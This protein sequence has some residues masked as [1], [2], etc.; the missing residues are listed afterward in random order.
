MF[1]LDDRACDFHF[2]AFE[3]DQY[4]LVKRECKIIK[5]AKRKKFLVLILRPHKI[6]IYNTRYYQQVYY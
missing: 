2:G 5:H 4:S 1:S 6:M 3:R